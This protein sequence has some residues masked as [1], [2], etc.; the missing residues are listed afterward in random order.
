MPAEPRLLGS[1]AM[2]GLVPDTQGTRRVALLCGW[3]W[4]TAADR[5]AVV[6]EIHSE[7][8][9]VALSFSGA[10]AN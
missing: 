6:T 10:P 7:L 8:Q 1:L 9:L 4:G 2:P 5:H 3:S